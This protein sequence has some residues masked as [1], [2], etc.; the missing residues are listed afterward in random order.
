MFLRTE[1][2]LTAMLRIFSIVL[3]SSLAPA[4]TRHDACEQASLW[5]M[6]LATLAKWGLFLKMKSEDLAKFCGFGRKTPPK[7]PNFAGIQLHL[8]AGTAAVSAFLADFCGGNRHAF[9]DSGDPSPLQRLC[10]P[11]GRKTPPSDA[12]KAAFRQR[13]SPPCR[14]VSLLVTL[15]GFCYTSRGDGLIWKKQQLIWKQQQTIRQ[16]MVGEWTAL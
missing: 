9:K 7:R 8:S 13:E 1:S 3:C 15:A 14:A 6:K 11:L 16:L 10:R 4:N 12:A 5:A 2:R